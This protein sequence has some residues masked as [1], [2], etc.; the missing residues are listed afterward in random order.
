MATSQGPIE[1]QDFLALRVGVS[2]RW[3]SN[4]FYGMSKALGFSRNLPSEGPKER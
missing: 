2:V 4:L 3:I 1:C